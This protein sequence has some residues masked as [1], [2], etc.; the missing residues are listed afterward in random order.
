MYEE[1]RWN[2]IVWAT[3]TLWYECAQRTGTSDDA[4]K[5]LLEMMAPC[6][7]FR[8]TCRDI[9]LTSA[10]ANADGSEQPEDPRQYQDDLD[11]LLKVSST[12]MLSRGLT[13]VLYVLDNSA[14]LIRANKNCSEQRKYSRY[15]QTLYDRVL[16]L[17]RLLS[18]ATSWICQGSRH[19]QYGNTFPCGALRS[20]G[21][22]VR[23]LAIRPLAPWLFEWESVRS[24]TCRL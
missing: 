15:A 7:Y 4:A 20:D 1:E 24:A 17:N 13:V 6:W 23:R 2:P 8:Q 22:P 5:L 16:S 9:S 14:K 18:A 11:V 21:R 10:I 12:Y 3:R 19:R